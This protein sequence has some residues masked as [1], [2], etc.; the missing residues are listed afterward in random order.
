MTF[1]S[2]F[3]F[4]YE[5][6]PY[7]LTVPSHRAMWTWMVLQL[8]HS[9]AFKGIYTVA[10]WLCLWSIITMTIAIF[11]IFDQISTL[12]SLWGHPLLQGTESQPDIIE[13]LLI[14]IIMWQ[15]WWLCWSWKKIESKPFL[16]LSL[17]ELPTMFCKSSASFLSL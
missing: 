7:W 6:F 4:F 10:N 15:Q 1:V 16:H 2:F 9:R 11:M 17:Q 14:L 3:L 13:V 12:Q 8:R 5:P